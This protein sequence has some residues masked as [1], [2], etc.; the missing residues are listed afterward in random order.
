MPKLYDEDQARVDEVLAKGVYRID[1]KPFSALRLLA[2]LA[3]V[4]LGIT[5]VSYLI[6]RHHGFV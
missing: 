1:R 4:L 6:A 2:V 5:V 3:G